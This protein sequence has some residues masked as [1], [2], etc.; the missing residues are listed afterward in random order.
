VLEYLWTAAWCFF[1]EGNADQWAGH[2]TLAIR[3]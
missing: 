3:S 2:H 1:A